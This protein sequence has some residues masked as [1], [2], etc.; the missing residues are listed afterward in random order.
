MNL[1][2]RRYKAYIHNYEGLYKKSTQEMSIIRENDLNLSFL[3][4]PYGN[5]FLFSLTPLVKSIEED[6]QSKMAIVWIPLEG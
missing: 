1:E 4:K 2:G 6:I 3:C 5:P